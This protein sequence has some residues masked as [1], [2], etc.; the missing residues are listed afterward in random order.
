MVIRPPRIKPHKFDTIVTDQGRECTNCLVFKPWSEFKHQTKSRTGHQ[1][2]C[3]ECLKTKRKAVGRKR[4][5]FSAS[6]R[7]IEIRQTDPF[8]YKASN[9][10]GRLLSRVTG[11]LKLSTPSRIEIEQWLHSQEPLHC[12]YSAAPLKITD[13]NVDHKTPLNRGG[14]NELDNLCVT[15]HHMNTAKGSMTELEFKALL[16]LISTW[17]DKGKKLL[18]RLKQGHF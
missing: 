5:L 16:N 15:S 1:E 9:L 2:R 14:T 7:R 6:K 10:R 17:E 11:S 18:T 3:R 12:Y 4:E 8:R 13:V